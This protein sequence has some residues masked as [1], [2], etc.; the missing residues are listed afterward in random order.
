[1]KNKLYKCKNCGRKI[2]KTIQ[3]EDKC[4]W[5]DEEYWDKIREEKERKKNELK[6]N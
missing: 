3:H 4:I 2:Y 5:C 1:M 6:T